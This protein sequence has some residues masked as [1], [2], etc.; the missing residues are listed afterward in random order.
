MRILANEN[1]S[2]TVIRTLRE[3]GHDV[4]SVKESLRGE[5]D[6]AILAQ[7]QAENRMVLTHDKDFGELAFRFGLPS[8]CGVILLRLA[9]VDSDADNCRALAAIESP[10]EWSGHISV[11]TEDRIRVRPLPKSPR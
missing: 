5:K 1:I 3:R 7:A 6:A 4:L 2:A 9:G 10:I 11:V 8:D